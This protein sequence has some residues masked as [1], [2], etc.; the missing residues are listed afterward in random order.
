MTRHALSWVAL[1]VSLW[2]ISSD[3][4]RL[5]VNGKSSFKWVSTGGDNIK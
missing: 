2:K 1:A 3:G 5:K 4:L